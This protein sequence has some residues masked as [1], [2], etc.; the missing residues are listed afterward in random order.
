[1]QF[2]H[3]SLTFTVLVPNILLNTLSPKVLQV[4]HLYRRRRSLSLCI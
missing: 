4:L 1:M 3:P 2:L